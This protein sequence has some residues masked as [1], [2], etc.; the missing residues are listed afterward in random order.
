MTCW[1]RS[2]P[3][4]CSRWR[5][6]SSAS[7]SASGCACSCPATSSTGSSPARCAFPRDRFNTANRQR[8]G[9]ILAEAFGGGQV[10]W[11]LQLSESVLV[12]VNYVI[13]C[14]RR[15]P[16]RLRRRRDR[17]A[18]R[19]GD[20]R[21]ERRP[22]G[23]AD[24]RHMGSSA[25]LELFARFRDAFPAAYRADWSAQGGG[26]R[27]R[28]DDRARAHR[29][30]DPG[31]VPDARAT[32][33]Q[34]SRCKLLS[35]SRGARCPTCCRRSSTWGR[36]CVDERPYEI[37]PSGSES[38]WVYDFGLQLPGGAA[39]AGGDAVRARRSSTCGRASSRTTGST[40]WCWPPA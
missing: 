18:D 6:G 3:R 10:D 23:R 30:P 8:A 31:A 19:R 38:V 26:R 39:G 21:L 27:H 11:S 12:R 17:G 1:S 40:G 25:G 33:E 13:R 22:A 16:R 9:Q 28:P 34:V 20:A 37:T 5:S 32:G 35:A 15:D 29:P 14:P 24:R 4:T 7:A 36:R 2:R